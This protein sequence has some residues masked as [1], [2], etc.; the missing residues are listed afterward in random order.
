MHTTE[1]P[2]TVVRSDDKKRAR[3]NI[4]R[5]IL[6]QLPYTD[7]D[8]DVIG[9]LDPKIVGV[10]AAIVPQDDAFLFGRGNKRGKTKR[11]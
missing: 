7:K 10:A 6:S 5:L 4:M 9:R 11:K 1:A 8:E 3:L 2:W